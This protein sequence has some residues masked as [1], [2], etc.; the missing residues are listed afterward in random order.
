MLDMSGYNIY[1][2]YQLSPIMFCKNNKQYY[3]TYFLYDFLRTKS[4]IRHDN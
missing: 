2:Y 4:F 3:Y 1:N